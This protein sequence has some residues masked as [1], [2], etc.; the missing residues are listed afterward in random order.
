MK[1]YK[2]DEF[3]NIAAMTARRTATYPER[4][5]ALPQITRALYSSSWAEASKARDKTTKRRANTLFICVC[6]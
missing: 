5:D 2:I 3:Y 1:T 6:N 4:V